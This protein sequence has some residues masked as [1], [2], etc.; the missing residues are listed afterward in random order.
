MPSQDS[1]HPAP[2]RL[3][4]PTDSTWRTKHATRERSGMARYFAL[5]RSSIRPRD[6]WIGPRRSSS[7][8]A[9]AVPMSHADKFEG[10]QK[11]GGFQQH[12]AGQ[13][14]FGNAIANRT[15]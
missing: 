6:S 7:V 5:D 13:A 9:R 15:K 12:V 2:C 10:D 4:R 3:L 14:F 1:S 11:D 8:S